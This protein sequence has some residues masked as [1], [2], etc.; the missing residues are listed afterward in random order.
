MSIVQVPVAVLRRLRYHA[1]GPVKSPWDACDITA[2]PH[3]R[4]RR[5]DVLALEY[6][7]QVLEPAGRMRAVGAVLENAAG[8]VL[9]VARDFADLLDV[10]EL[11]L[12]E[13]EFA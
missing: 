2:T 4:H 6:V 8:D 11:R 10:E 12:G 13:V 9:A 1:P 5:E 3:A 7:N